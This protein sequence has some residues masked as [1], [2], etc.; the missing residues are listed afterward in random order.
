M[1]QPA[2]LQNDSIEGQDITPLHPASA[3]QSSDNSIDL[4]KFTIGSITEIPRKKGLFWLFKVITIALCLLMILTALI[5]LSEVSGVE[6]SGRIFVATYMV[7]FSVLLMIF[8]ISQ[9]RPCENID[10]MFKRNF[11]FL[12][13]TKGKALFIIFVAF[14]SFG[15]TEPATLCFATGFMFACLGGVQIA[16]YLKYPELF[17]D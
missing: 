9:I 2:W 13:G 16:M 10:F 11:G 7:F 17:D 8:E 3:P 6:E 14:L 4:S 1:S 15:L 12:Y 5:G